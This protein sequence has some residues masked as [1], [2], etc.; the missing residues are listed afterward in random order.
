MISSLCRCTDVDEPY[1]WR[2][3][4][5]TRVSQWRKTTITFS[6]MDGQC[7]EWSIADQ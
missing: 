3:D 6:C 4:T 2:R 5:S 7:S 1:G